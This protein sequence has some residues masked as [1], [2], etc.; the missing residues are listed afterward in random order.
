MVLK[1]PGAA[2]QATKTVAGHCGRKDVRPILPAASTQELA[3]LAPHP[4]RQ[5]GW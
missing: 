3:D 2:N 5:V 4:A 1:S